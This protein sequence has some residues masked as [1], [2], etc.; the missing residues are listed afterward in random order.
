[1]TRH[2]VP[3]DTSLVEEAAALYERIAERAR[4]LKTK[5][6]DET[7]DAP[8]VASPPPRADVSRE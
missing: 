4:E 1:M 2:L 8:V 5:E 6:G 7:S 3:H